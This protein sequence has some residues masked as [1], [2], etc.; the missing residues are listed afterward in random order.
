[1]INKYNLI[2]ESIEKIFKKNSIK[3]LKCRNDWE[4]N[5][6]ESIINIIDDKIKI[7]SINE[8]QDQWRLNFVINLILTTI[9]K[10][11][12]NLNCN[13]ILSL[14]DSASLYQK[15][16]RLCFSAPID[17]NHILIP[18]PHL[19]KY[20]NSINILNQFD[21]PFE[22]KE[23]KICFYGSATGEI[24][25]ELMNQRV[26]FCKKAIGKDHITAKITNFL[27]FKDEMLDDLGI[28]K[29]EIESPF[30]SI[31]EQLKYKFIL[32]I[33]GNAASWDRIP[34]AMNS[35]SYLIHLKSRKDINNWYYSYITKENILPIYDEDDILNFNFSYNPE[36][37][38]KQ[39]QFANLILDENIQIEYVKEVLLK[40]NKIYNG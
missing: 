34:W 27:Y 11:T 24:T 6:N 5:E 35:N 12:L 9:K 15:Y 21:L 19:F 17:S 30:I 37:K 14:A 36:I 28:K 2:D 4:L 22:N 23:N 26:S 38:Q 18:D 16:T 8:K 20:I 25:D 10:Y 1:M 29:L 7:I 32:S 3:H 39:K 40:Y 13:V 31:E 33:D